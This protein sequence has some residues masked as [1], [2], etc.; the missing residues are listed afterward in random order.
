MK[1]VKRVNAKFLGCLD[2]MFT[3]AASGIFCF[4][5]KPHFVL[6]LFKVFCLIGWMLDDSLHPVPEPTLPRGNLLAQ[7]ITGSAIQVA[8][9]A[10]HGLLL[11]DEGIV[12]SWGDNSYGQLGRGTPPG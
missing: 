10:K 11:T 6:F 3:A 7:D 5:F 1:E 12:Y 9:G 8:V 2:S 4:D